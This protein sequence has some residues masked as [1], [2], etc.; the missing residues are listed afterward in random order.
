MFLA[1]PNTLHL[2]FYCPKNI[3]SAIALVPRKCHAEYL[4]GRPG[5][6]FFK[7]ILR[8]VFHKKRPRRAFSLGVFCIVLYATLL[9]IVAGT[10]YRI[11]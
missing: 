5:E 4:H 1:A 6:K 2:I 3:T 7:I 8:K 10:L 11:G 9:N